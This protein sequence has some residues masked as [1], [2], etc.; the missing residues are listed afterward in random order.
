MSEI[1]NKPLP[2]YPPAP[3]PESGKGKKEGE[4]K[5]VEVDAKVTPGEMKAMVD[6]LKD[7]HV[8][9]VAVIV[10]LV[11]ALFQTAVTV[12]GLVIDAYR[13]KAETY[14]NLVN[15]IDAQNIILQQLP[16]RKK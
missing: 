11:L 7:L 6:K 8:I 10:I 12:A 13:F 2:T 9:I 15:K 1:D 5:L 3:A 4:P 16:V 14:Q